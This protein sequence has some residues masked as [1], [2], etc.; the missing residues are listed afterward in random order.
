MQ[1]ARSKV[2]YV[3]GEFIYMLP[4]DMNLRIGKVKNHNN[5]ILISSPSFKIGT[6]VKINLDGEKDKQYVKS[7]EVEMVKSEPDVNQ[8]KNLM[9]SPI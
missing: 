8:K 1:Y 7:K 6:N 9:S 2:D 5:K 3:I 4:S